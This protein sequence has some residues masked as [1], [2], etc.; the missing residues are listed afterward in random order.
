MKLKDLISQTSWPQVAIDLVTAYPNQ[1]KSIE[2]YANVYEYLWQI[3][4]VDTETVIHIEKTKDD[5]EPE[6]YY[7]HLYGK[8]QE[9]DGVTYGLSYCPWEEWLGM[10]IAS[11]TMA[12]YTECEIVAICLYEMT[13][14][15][16]DEKTIDSFVK[17]FLETDIPELTHEFIEINESLT[18]I[19]YE[20]KPT[21]KW[22]MSDLTRFIR[23]GTVSK[24]YFGKKREWLIQN[25]LTDATSAELERIDILAL[26]GAL[27]DIADEINNV[28]EKL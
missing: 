8:K 24:E 3:E 5:F 1:R 21:V 22:L 2:G 4:P 7:D 15:G 9:D 18:E 23:W 6:L 12:D 27:K 28:I 13:W 11:E 16:F 17:K 10:E 19:K 20:F 25:I 14:A 26:K